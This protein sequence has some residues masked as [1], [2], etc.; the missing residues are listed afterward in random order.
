MNK[1]HPA[2]NKRA[3][4]ETYMPNNAY[5]CADMA[6]KM[7]IVALL[8]L[9][10]LPALAEGRLSVLF[11]NVENLFDCRH[12]TL[13]ND[14]EFLPDGTR[15]WTPSRYWHKLDN[16]ARTLAA[17]TE[18][19][20]D[21]PMLV[22]LAE[23][24]NDSCMFDLTRRST[25]R[26]AGYRYVMTDCADARGI[27]VALLYQ[28][29]RFRLLDWHSVRIPSEV[30]GLAPT[31]DILY[32]CGQT[33]IGDTLHVVVVHLP[34]RAG[35]KRGSARHRR[36][37]AETLRHLTDSLLGKQLLV[38]GDFNTSPRDALFRTLAPPLVSLMP[39]SRR[40]L[41]RARGTYV[42]QGQWSYLD[43]MLVSPQLLP[44][45]A[46]QRAEPLAFPF[47]LN[48]KGR[49]WRTYQGPAYVGGFSDHLPLRLVLKWE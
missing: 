22:G 14:F 28:P 36:L 41:R 13:Q 31:R 47:L 27:D 44:F 21:W 29:E 10:S 40:E 35:N 25:L 23:V 20:G 33:A 46:E 39:Q 9:S 1:V 38:M 26:T 45:V 5:I 32:V 6:K 4:R 12:D 24:E 11:W 18:A 30:H 15:H 37:A 3:P 42:F 17:A 16:I 2:S 43:H 8:M 19:D 34:S 48:E 7:F 49:P